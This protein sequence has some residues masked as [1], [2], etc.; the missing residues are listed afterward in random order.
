MNMAVSG[1]AAASTGPQPKARREISV[2]VKAY[3]LVYNG[4]LTAG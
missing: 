4:V 2:V 1:V 3:L